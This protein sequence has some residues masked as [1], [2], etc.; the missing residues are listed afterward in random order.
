MFAAR[1]PKGKAEGLRKYLKRKGLLNSKYR[2]FGSGEFIYFPVSQSADGK[3][4][5]KLKE[6]G[7]KIVAADFPSQRHKREKSQRLGYEL[8]GS[9]A[10]IESDAGSAGAAGRSL[11]TSNKNIRTVLRKG[12]AVSGKYRTRKFLYVSGKKNFI[13][14]YRENGC[15]FRFDIRKVFFSTKLAFERKRVSGLVRDGESVIV[16]FAGVGPFA[17]EIAKSHSRCKVIAIELNSAACRSMRENIRLNKTPNVIPEQG[18]VDRFAAKYAGF[19]DRIIM[20][21]PKE[22]S[23]FLPTALRM[24]RKGCTIHYYT[25]CQSGK[26]DAAV[27]ELK[28]LVKAR[29]RGFRLLAH[30][31]VRPYSAVDEEIVVDFKLG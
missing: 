8:Y 23:K 24:S 28:G 3:L 11:M 6:M 20:P 29:K 5:L 9:I 22:S 12:S 27:A 30:R 26:A 7:A 13:A 16:M 17:I 18:D 10:V 1:V 25:F 19:A 31:T 14:D 2:V 4:A 15:V 21:L